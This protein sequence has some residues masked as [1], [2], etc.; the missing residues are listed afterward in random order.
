[1]S[2]TTPKLQPIVNEFS[3]CERS[4]IARLLIHANDLYKMY[5]STDTAVEDKKVSLDKA[6]K[7]ITEVINFDPNNAPAMN[8][9]GRIELDRGNVSAAKELFDKCLEHSPENTQYLTNL[10][11]LHIISEEP[12]L[13]IRQFE[14]ALSIDNGNKNAFL[15]MARAHHALGHF[16]VAYL[17][18]RSLINHG[19][20]DI[21]ILHGMLNCCPHIKIESYN[22]QLEADLFLL[23]SKSELALD[24]LA[25]FAAALLV[26]KYD[27]S[28]PNATIEMLEVAKDPLVYYSLLN[29]ILPDPHVEE[30]ITLLRQSILLECV[31][32]GTL[33]DDLQVLAIAIA[34]Y[35]ERTNFALIVDEVEEEKVELIDQSL[36]HTL[37]HQ[38]EVD[39]VAGALIVVGMYKAFFSQTYAVNL[40]A[41]ELDQWPSALLPLMESSLYRRAERESFKQQFPEKKSELL[42]SKDDLPGPFPRRQT[43]DFFNQQ[44]L[45]QELINNF[46]LPES[47]LPER[48]LLLVAG[49]NASQRALEYAN[50]FNDV[51]VLALENSLENLAEC[52]LKAHQKGLSNIVFWPQSLAK[53]F[54]E[55]GNQIHFASISA[56]APIVDA[57]FIEL[58]KRQLCTNG[59]LNIKL[60][61]SPDN[62]S[63]DIETLVA[64]QGLRNTSAN[65][66]ALRSTILADKYS[67][68][69][70][71]LI[72]EEYFYS[73][74][75]C[76][77]AWFGS[78]DQ[79]PVLNTAIEL[80]S[81]SDWQLSKVLNHYGKAVSTALAKKNLLKIAKTKQINHDYSIYLA[82][83]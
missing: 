83:R 70:E 3:D 43:I 42:T 58:V 22:T 45:K 55:D 30:F 11:Y 50:H 82:K 25:G 76:R 31:E 8:L 59:M 73:I 74:D 47:E 13:A 51:D 71:G 48:L 72:N 34:V 63:A 36:Q 68:Y 2:P 10:G 81:S 46:Q 27:L 53:R 23:L 65:I 32:S 41:L 35:A 15:G 52:H 20:D 24:K 21:T 61:E 69:W 26:K 12:E 67:A 57:E 79:K 16:D 9:L 14:K 44:S 66:R 37:Q 1:M 64:K 54:L 28:N 80:S 18:Y 49:T 78:N 56:E 40:T 75:G 60:C 4:D 6:F 77:Q 19:Y 5:N 33:R 38:W 39:E 7:L 29:C 17:H 62:A